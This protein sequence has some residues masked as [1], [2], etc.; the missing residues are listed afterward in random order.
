LKK[1]NFYR[2]D[3]RLQELLRNKGFNSLLKIQEDSIDSNFNNENLLIVAPTA[4]GK[5]EAALLPIISS[6]MSDKVSKPC[7]KCIYIAPLKALLNDIENR[8]IDIKDYE[9][10]QPYILK[11]H[12][13]V[14][15]SKKL[16]GLKDVPD[17][18]LI[19]PESL[20]VL[21]ISPHI[22]QVELLE[23]VR[24]IVIDEVHNF[25]ATPRG[26]QLISLISRIEN[27]SKSSIQKIG[28]SATVGNPD[29]ILEWMTNKSQ[30]ISKYLISEDTAKKVK[31]K[32]YHIEDD[33]DEVRY[34]KILSTLCKAGKTIIFNNSRFYAEEIS[35]DLEK[36]NI[37]CYVHHGSLSKFIREEAEDKIKNEIKGVISATSTLELGID[38]G[39]LDK[40]IQFQNFSSV[41]SFLQRLGRTGRRSGLN[42][43]IVSVTDNSYDFLINLAIISLGVCDKFT[44]P[45]IPST[46]RYDI[47][48]QQLLSQS[49]SYYGVRKDK[50][51]DI[52]KEAYC[53]SGITKTEYD[54][55][56][57]FWIANGIIRNVNDDILIGDVGEKC[58]G[59]RNHLE[60]YSVFESNDQYEVI[61]N[62]YS[63]GV[64]DSWF[65][66][67]K[68]GKFLF[69]LAGKKWKVEE[70]D[71]TRK[72]IY[73]SLTSKGI[74]PVW[75][76][77]SFS[78][79]DYKVAQRV[80]EIIS[81]E[82]DCSIYNLDNEEKHL[83]S[84]IKKNKLYY[85][86]S[87]YEILITKTENGFSI[88]TYAG[89]MI[90]S[91]LNYL[92]KKH[93]GISSEFVDY[94]Y[95]SYKKKTYTEN[96][97]KELLL[98]IKSD[99]S[100]ENIYNIIFN[101]ITIWRYSKYSE[102][103]PDD[104]SKKFIISEYYNIDEFVNYFKKIKINFYS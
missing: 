2:L 52:V 92:I 71:D 104:L 28:L 56:V 46:L 61:Y 65:V 79:I 99:L 40:A 35:K 63:I 69:R 97:F 80:R 103:I 66:K 42:P 70:I 43:F 21:F 11:W 23:K 98:K 82:Y 51:W 77:G 95:I 48:L 49:L 8:L 4:S 55:L 50:F 88:V 15:R 81:C 14:S 67:S 36:L 31:I 24:Y 91:I 5:T 30:L 33:I 6:I 53:F 78:S 29:R 47:L 102:F 101:E 90:N 26:A 27:I 38:I 72:L 89:T 12:G 59:Y 60:L 17:I 10:S 96:K 20:E 44:E 93:S 100:Y 45:I 62:K 39:D 1:S 37:E 13:D 74:S 94:F 83:L 76:G 19:T 85:R 64:L 25:S 16:K 3:S 32:I 73:V 75:M 57:Q 34:L 41:N 87:E 58:F 7:L 9:D 86:T 68:Q 18:L 84:S 22:N 54:Y